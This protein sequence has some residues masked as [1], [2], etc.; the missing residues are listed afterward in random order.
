MRLRARVLLIALSVVLGV[1]GV[2]TFFTRGISEELLAHEIENHLR[3]TVQSRGRLV[4]TYLKGEKDSLREFAKGPTAQTVLKASKAGAPDAEALNRL[5]I[6]MDGYT[7]GEGA[8]LEVMLIDDS[9]RI[10]LSSAS[11]HGGSFVRETACFK[12]SEFEACACGPQLIGDRKGLVLTFVAPVHDELDDSLLGRVAILQPMLELN[13]IVGEYEG[14]GPSGETYILDSSGVMIT[15]SLMDPHAP[16]LSVNVDTH[17]FQVG[18]STFD[19]GGQPI[20]ATDVFTY[21]NYK[22][23]EV[24]GAYAPVFEMDWIVV[25]ERATDDAFAP[26]RTLEKAIVGVFTLLGVLAA[27]FAVYLSRTITR[28]ILELKAGA[29]ELASGNLGHTVD[30]TRSDE[31]GDLARV[32]NSM[33][34]KLWHARERLEETV[35]TRTAELRE[36][37]ARLDASN[38]ELQDFAYVASHDLREP[39]RKVSSFGHL[40]SESLQGRIDEDE[41]E[42]LG[43]MVDG[44]TRMQVMIEDLLTYSRVTTKGKPFEKVDINDLVRDIESLDMATRIEETEGTLQVQAELPPVCADASQ[45]RQLF[46]N[47]IGNAMKFHRIGVKPHVEISGV[48]TGNNMIEV[49]VQDNGIGIP[50]EYSEQVFDMFKRLHSRA[51]YEGTGIGLAVCRKIVERHGGQIAVESATGEGST[52]RFTLPAFTGRMTHEEGHTHAES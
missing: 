37:N 30:D 11:G 40:L 34:E 22:Q 44:A 14:L 27:L 20:A 4:D 18:R 48:D 39:L 1:G 41:R 17:I 32:F 9:G 47:L 23:V 29:T 26:L 8:A 38:R 6:W 50:A 45:M 35:A 31:I 12:E 13:A 3:T 36:A 2:I 42:N 16:P 43:F 46:Q 7:Q 33:S 10:I 19:E 49:R 28:P 24:I 51:Q 21:D 25:T 5:R 15:P 52:F